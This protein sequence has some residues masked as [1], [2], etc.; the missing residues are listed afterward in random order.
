MVPVVV[1]LQN[2]N[3]TNGISGARIVDLAPIAYGSRGIDLTGHQ[4]AGFANVPL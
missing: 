3:I 1:E 2:V 4:L